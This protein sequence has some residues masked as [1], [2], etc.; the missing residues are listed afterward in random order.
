MINTSI[1]L[2]G[3]A[4]QD[5]KDSAASE[6]SYV[7]GLTGGKTF[8]LDRSVAQADVSCGVRAGTDSYVESV[9]PGLDFETYGYAD[10]MPLYFYA[11]MGNIVST[12]QGGG[13]HSHVVTL[14][15]ILP[16][17][18]FWGRVGGEYTRTEGCKV[19]TLEMDFE[20]NAPL[21]FGVTV[22]GMLAALG[23]DD[24]YHKQ[25]IS[26]L[27]ALRAYREETEKRRI[28]AEAERTIYTPPGAPRKPLL[29][30]TR[31]FSTS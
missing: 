8:Q 17:L 31:L 1:G 23:L 11:A 6:P 14:G 24:P 28:A 18:T 19:D 12:P 10:A 15:D 25:P 9:T 2:I 27:E 30:N 16:Y 5:G 29:A 20:G 7:H 3:V 22:L 21:E 26:D 13:L 4:L